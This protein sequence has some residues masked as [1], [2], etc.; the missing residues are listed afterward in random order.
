[1]HVPDNIKKAI[2]SSSYNYKQAIESRDEIRDWL[3]ANEINSDFMKDYLYE[4]IEN[5]TD[6]RRDFLEHLETHTKE[7]M[8]DGTD[9]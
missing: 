7:Q 6:N 4:C 9:D 3:E 2:I 5:G 8:Y 1:M